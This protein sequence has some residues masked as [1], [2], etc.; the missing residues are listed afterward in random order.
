MAANPVPT[1]ALTVTTEKTETGAV[2]HCSGRIVMENTDELRQTA[3]EQ[4]A[5]NKRVVLDFTGV[6]YLDSSG[7]G[8]IVGL[9]LASKRSGCRLQ[10]INLTPRV[11]EIFTLTRLTEALEGHEEL[12]GLTPD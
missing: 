3:R 2:V 9:L 11:R 4:I 7:L 8:M 6:T 12:L 1:P 5:Q 10:L